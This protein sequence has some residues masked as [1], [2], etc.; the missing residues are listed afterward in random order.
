MGITLH[1]LQTRATT[2]R[3]ASVLVLCT[4]LC[5]PITAQQPG[6]GAGPMGDVPLEKLTVEQLIAKLQE[7]SE[8]GIGTHATAW[9]SGFIAVDEEPQ[10]G[11]GILGS[12]KPAK[13]P[14]MRELVR[15]GT[16][17]LPKLLEHVDDKRP[18]KLV[19]EHTF[20][21]GGMWHSDEYVHRYAD[22]KKQPAKVN[23]RKEVIIE[24]VKPKYT[25]RVGDLCYVAVGQIV[26]CG[27]NVLR[28]Q[29]T[30][31]IVINSPVETPSLAAAVRKDW[32]GLT[33]DQHKQSLIQDANSKYP[34][35]TPA[36]IRRLL[37]YF[38]KDGEPLAVKLLSRPLYNEHAIQI[39]AE[40]LVNEKESA[41]W[42]AMIAEFRRKHGNGAA[43]AVPFQ[44]RWDYW[45]TNTAEDEK[46]RLARERAEKILAQEFPTYD[47]YQ[48][49]FINGASFSEQEE[50][51]E[52]LASVRSV[53][54]DK[55]AYDVFLAALR[56][57]VSSDGDQ[58]LR[59]R[60]AIGCM[61][62]LVGKGHDDEFRTYVAARIKAIGSPAPLTA[63]RQSLDAFQ[64]L[65]KR[66]DK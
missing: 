4:L 7:E 17:A 44:L 64:E 32:S 37:F 55:V 34:F 50:L 24:G 8:Q 9:A 25:I 61:S 11:G 6:K 27:L 28:Y 22:P 26:N 23:T 20:G 51:V 57:K 59:E 63:Q 62:R 3:W 46:E 31:C 15:R 21:I 53:A 35:V 52:S 48:P 13:S 33:A 16:D 60:L 19:I 56:A 38:P 1:C 18:T 29:P 30:A 54:I 36:A 66:L 42:K 40:R 14:V 10:F 49:P 5:H 41:K 39:F 43:D 58:I 45:R 65:K 47:P 2:L 12:Q